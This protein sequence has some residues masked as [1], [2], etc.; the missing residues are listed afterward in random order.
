M[1]IVVG[2]T[3]GVMTEV[4]EG[5][6]QAQTIV[7]DSARQAEGGSGGGQRPAETLA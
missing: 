3:A 2:I 4:K 7:A 1:R 6:S 5:L